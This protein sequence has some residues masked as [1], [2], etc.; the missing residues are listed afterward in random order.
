[1]KNKIIEF[2]I[3]FIPSK[4]KR[5]KL[6]EKYYMCELQKKYSG[7][8]PASNGKSM[9]EFADW[10]TNWSDLKVENIFEIGANYAQD[11]EALM[12]KFKLTSKDV[13]VFE[14]HPDL[15]KKIKELH[16]FNAFPYAVYNQ[17]TQLK[18]NICPSTGANTGTSSLLK[19][20]SNP[21][22]NEVLV[23]AVRMDDFMNEH[24]IEKIDFLKL[25][26]EGSNYEV[27]EG[28]GSRLK[29]VNSI[30]IEAE[31]EPLWEGQK[32]YKDIAKLLSDNDFELVKFQRYKSQSDSFWIQKKY[33]RFD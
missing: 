30:H 8:N 2:F 31:H 3:N 6:K 4:H 17:K 5:L 14:A 27:I 11:A 1:M 25:D 20:K 24:N 28:F 32:L 15:Y 33:L 18:F 9:F 22:E 26:V 29:D 7:L 19:H 21:L 23:D 10:I 16:S 13:W 12:F